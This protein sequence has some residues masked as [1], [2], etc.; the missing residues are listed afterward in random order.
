MSKF[1]DEVSQFGPS[2]E[3]RKELYSKAVDLLDCSCN[4]LVPRGRLASNGVW[5]WTIQ[6]LDCGLLHGDRDGNMMWVKKSH[7][8]VMQAADY[9]EIDDD[10]RQ[11]TKQRL[12]FVASFLHQNEWRQ[13][14]EFILSEWRDY[15][16]FL[17]TD[18]WQR[19]REKVLIRDNKLC[20]LNHF[21]RCLKKASIVHHKTYIR[22]R[23][24]LLIDLISCCRPCHEWEHPHLRGGDWL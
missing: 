13:D 15:K 5:H 21:H 2:W 14:R 17:K 16:A 20:Q 12:R 6:C 1:A 7:P 19:L 9:I 11:E 24:K 22:W 4:N 23:E 18:E 10:L 3:R 8:I